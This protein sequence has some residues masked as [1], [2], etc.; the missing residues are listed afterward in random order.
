MSAD[1]EALLGASVSDA[2]TPAPRRRR[3]A[4]SPPAT[5]PIDLETIDLADLPDAGA[6]VRQNAIKLAGSGRAFIEVGVLKR[7]VSKNFLAL[8]FDMDPATV[9]KRLLNCPTVGMAGG[10]RPVYDFRTALGYLIPPQM[11]IGEYIESLDPNDLPNHIS[12]AYWEAKRIRVRF[13]L[14]A[15]QAWATADVAEVF[16]GTWMTLKTQM[17]RLPEMLRERCGLTEE[18]FDAAVAACDA[19]Q[20]ELHAKLIQ[21]PNLRQTRSLAAEFGD[22]AEAAQP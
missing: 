20:N 21:A 3:R 10:G 17:Q 4:A 1:I 16:G 7:P 14:E 9:T 2:P 12:R 15:G 22:E 13:L 18:Q 19:C 6:I 8:L 11:D 5:T